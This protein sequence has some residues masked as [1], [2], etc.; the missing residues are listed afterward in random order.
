MPPFDIAGETL[1]W[2][3]LR[4]VLMLCLGV[5]FGQHHLFTVEDQGRCL[6]APTK[7]IRRISEKGVS[8]MWVNTTRLLQQK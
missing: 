1:S 3:N 6:L 2:L 7:Y 5:T 8:G 4:G